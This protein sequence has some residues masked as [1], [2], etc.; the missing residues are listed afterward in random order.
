M[1]ND[2]QL[3]NFSDVIDKKLNLP[4]YSN[5]LSKA[6]H[7]IDKLKTFIELCIKYDEL[8]P[9]KHIE[10]FNEVVK[11]LDWVGRLSK[12]CFDVH[13]LVEEMY[14]VRFKHSPA[15]AKKLWQDHTERIHHPYTI[16]KNRCFRLIDDLDDA[17][18]KKF[19]QNPPNWE[20]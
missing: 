4:N 7:N 8:T 13:D 1:E 19:K 16:L 14:T 12:P 9:A 6:E 11:Q 3:I 5:E 15:L 18:I 10:F 2:E 17:Y 20:I